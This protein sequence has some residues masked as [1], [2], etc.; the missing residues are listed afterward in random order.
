MS[1]PSTVSEVFFFFFSLLFSLSKKKALLFAGEHLASSL[2]SE[3][4]TSCNIVLDAT[5]PA[6]ADQRR[7]SMEILHEALLRQAAQVAAKLYGEAAS[8]QL[9]R[10]LAHIHDAMGQSAES[11]SWRNRASLLEIEN[12]GQAN[13]FDAALRDP[14][15]SVLQLRLLKMLREHDRARELLQHFDL[16]REG[17]KND[18]VFWREGSALLLEVVTLH[19]SRESHLAYLTALDTKLRIGVASEAVP[20]QEVLEDVDR[21]K[22]ALDNAYSVLARNDPK[23][24]EFEAR[25][26]WHMAL[27]HQRNLNRVSLTSKLSTIQKAYR[28]FLRALQ[29]LPDYENV[30]DEKIRMACE[31]V[32][33]AGREALLL[34]KA[35]R[36]MLEVSQQF[37]P[38]Q[39]RDYEEFIATHEQLTETKVL[40]TLS[41]YD[42]MRIMS[43]PTDKQT[44]LH[45]GLWYIQYGKPQ[46]L[47]GWWRLLSKTAPAPAHVADTWREM[48][49]MDAKVLEA[50]LN[51][52]EPLVATTPAPSYFPLDSSFFANQGVSTPMVKSVASERPP[53]T[54]LMDENSSKKAP[55][56]SARAEN[57]FARLEA[58]RAQ[59]ADPSSPV[60][61]MSAHQPKPEAQRSDLKK[62]AFQGRKDSESSE[63][64]VD[65]F[66]SRQIAKAIGFGDE[67]ANVSETKSGR[68]AFSAS[69][70][71]A[72]D[73]AKQ[74]GSESKGKAEEKKKESGKKKEQ[75]P[76]FGA[77]FELPKDPLPGAEK[78]ESGK[79]K[80]Q[81]PSFGAA[82][83]LPKEPLPGAEKKKEG[84][85]KEQ[86][87]SFGAAFELPKEPLPGAEKKEG[88]KKKEKLPGAEK[89]EKEQFGQVDSWG[90]VGGFGEA[91][92]L[93]RFGSGFGG[94]SFGA[95]AVGGFAFGGAEAAESKLPAEED[96]K[97]GMAGSKAEERKKDA[98]NEGSCAFGFGDSASDSFG[99]WGSKA[100]S[101]KD[102][103]A[104]FGGSDWPSGGFESPF[105]S[106]G[107]FAAGSGFGTSDNSSGTWPA[108]SAAAPGLSSFGAALV[109]EERKDS[110]GGFGA[111]DNVRQSST[112][113]DGQGG[114]RGLTRV[115]RFENDL[116]EAAGTAS[117]SSEESEKKRDATSVP[118]EDDTNEEESKKEKTLQVASQ[119]QK[120]DTTDALATQTEKA[121]EIIQMQLQKDHAKQKPEETAFGG[122]Q[123]EGGFDSKGGYSFAAASDS[124]SFAP[125]TPIVPSAVVTEKL[126]SP[127]K[128][129]ASKEVASP[130]GAPSPLPDMA[131]MSQSELE[132][133]L[134]KTMTKVTMYRGMIPA[135]EKAVEAADQ[136]VRRS[137]VDMLQKYTT[138]LQNSITLRGA[139]EEILLK[140]FNVKTDMKQEEEMLER[141]YSVV[142][143]FGSEPAPSSEK[144]KDPKPAELPVSSK[145]GSKPAEKTTGSK[146]QKANK[147]PAE[148]NPFVFGGKAT[149]GGSPKKEGRFGDGPRFGGPSFEALG[150][151]FESEKKE[152]GGANKGFGFGFEEQKP[153]SSEGFGF[154]DFGNI[155]AGT[156]GFG[157]GSELSSKDAKS[158][159]AAGWVCI[160]CESE[161]GPSDS[162][163]GVCLVPKP[164]EEERLKNA[165]KPAPKTDDKA[166]GNE[167]QSPPSFGFAFGEGG[168]VG[169]GVGSENNATSAT[170]GFTFSNDFSEKDTKPVG[171][172]GWTCIA[173]ESENEAT[174]STCGVCLV[175][176][177]SDQE[178]QKSA[179]KPNEKT[180]EKAGAGLGNDNATGFGLGDT[181]GGGV[182]KKSSAGSG[183]GD[184]STGAGFGGFMVPS[185]TEGF[186]GFG[187][188]TGF[189]FAPRE[190]VVEQQAAFGGFGGFGSIPVATDQ[191]P[192]WVCLACETENNA[193]DNTCG[194]CLV[195]RP[196]EEEKQ[197]S[198]SKLA[199]KPD[200]KSNLGVGG[201]GVAFGTTSVG[202]GF[203]A[204]SFG[205]VDDMKKEE[206]A[207]TTTEATPKSFKS[208]LATESPLS[209]SWQ[210]LNNDCDTHNPASA[211]ACIVC[212]MPQGEVGKEIAKAAEIKEE[213]K[214]QAA[215]R[216]VTEE[217]KTGPT[218]GEGTGLV[219]GQETGGKFVF[220]ST[221]SFTSAVGSGAAFSFEDKP[222]SSEKKEETFA[223]FAP[224]SFGKTQEWPPVPL[225]AFAEL[226]SDKTKEKSGTSNMKKDIGTKK[227]ERKNEG[228][229]ALNFEFDARKEGDTVLFAFGSSGAS[230]FV[231][232]DFDLGVGMPTTFDADAFGAGKT[233][234]SV[235][236]AP[237][238]S[239]HELGS[240]ADTEDEG[241][242]GGDEDEGEDNGESGGEDDGEGG[243]SSSS[244]TEEERGRGDSAARSHD[245]KG[246]RE[247]VA[248]VHEKEPA[249]NADDSLD[250][251]PEA[252]GFNFGTMSNDQLPTDFGST[253]GSTSSFSFDTG[254]GA[255]ADAPTA[256]FMTSEVKLPDFGVYGE[257]KAKEEKPKEEK[258]KLSAQEDKSTAR[259]PVAP[260]PSHAPAPS[261]APAPVG[262][263]NE[264]KIVK[265]VRR[266]RNTAAPAGDESPFPELGETPAK[267]KAAGHQGGGSS[268]APK[269]RIDF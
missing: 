5:P 38:E 78:K 152:E 17:L 34:V 231:M 172:A 227:E 18:A 111:S 133:L 185:T 258:P 7:R 246:P 259:G 168:G 77:A 74:Q 61:H 203:G 163:C 179:S 198:A 131:G 248:Q 117:G 225:G 94:S 24:L 191:S 166:V 266:S 267:E 123:D 261:L 114:A 251:A 256:S 82:F 201:E 41:S 238:V 220:E 20:L 91:S 64:S 16:V 103:S 269:K 19:P 142:E 156:T 4:V 8:V 62:S 50:A 121:K 14:Q 224:F 195:P 81:L 260:T 237:A 105:G 122:K 215:P 221:P 70:W 51:S 83:E 46:V 32:R 10:R 128:T 25:T 132:G 110:S 90:S 265:A 183:F 37:P 115:Q 255:T 79:K 48:V 2:F 116:A 85:K 120:A 208:F 205:G 35:T 164:S 72:T 165:S 60:A 171:G 154:G 158:T 177:P 65:E 153:S 95:A 181:F 192:G 43:N 15:N 155:P 180:E 175:P 22:K 239:N 1:D 170:T 229:A 102:S 250:I 97:A 264:R 88:E 234:F 167:K 69:S 93:Q 245:K 141:R 12:N 218:F 197:K 73:A 9:A 100:N 222:L 29:F 184:V 252:F 126:A 76:S 249:R 207:E 263:A 134:Q 241:D 140:R 47:K 209:R 6:H 144:P 124:F 253:F 136:V 189:E 160:A 206:G 235:G 149:F 26:F 188:A 53:F 125:S 130:S 30:F 138:L 219:F 254:A 214:D 143:E 210:C 169:F 56:S 127:K 39:K 107:G 80:E 182:A 268:T 216:D 67:P 106:G 228:P 139:V 89:Q 242:V 240:D 27:L 40:E 66:M 63:T 196:S 68:A 190:A 193:S 108:F 71:G 211:K 176:K 84:E 236:R 157:V 199:A 101:E 223:G 104:G 178:R 119:L 86:L 13:V 42:K 243:S 159:G 49:C 226:E 113:E 161:N 109:A 247:T 112:E 54:P 36:D 96:R 151:G 45:D 21:F 11:A 148:D 186:G 174:D 33:G 135:M 146:G 233:V 262:A 3:C 58:L 118:L 204:S 194:V 162:A 232:P 55:A 150:F 217:K 137:K 99:G 202:F 213:I 92:S 147:L 31:R 52:E 187:A 75:L 57:K 257:A 87:P 145:K 173:C 244:S 230:D 129:P 28:C 23:G 59:F 44:I 98:E 212:D 200:E